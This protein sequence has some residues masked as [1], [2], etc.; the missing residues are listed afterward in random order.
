[1]VCFSRDADLPELW[2]ELAGH[3]ERATLQAANRLDRER[4]PCCVE[5]PG[6]QDGVPRQQGVLFELAWCAAALVAFMIVPDKWVGVYAI[7]TLAGMFIF[8]RKRKSR[9]VHL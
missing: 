4:P 9:S 7:T 1:M 6:L 2:G 8:A 5:V 3:R